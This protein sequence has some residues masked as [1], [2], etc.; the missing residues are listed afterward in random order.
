VAIGALNW[1]PVFAGPIFLVV[2]SSALALGLV[3]RVYASAKGI[4]PNDG[5][6][7]RFYRQRLSLEAMLL[8]AGLLMLAGLGMDSYLF[9][10]WVLGAADLNIGLQLAA[11]A[12][13]SI[14]VGAHLGLAGFLASMMDIE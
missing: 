11:L 13:T 14:I 8:S 1:Q 10:R 5:R 4:I 12:Q 7:A 2:G 3:S 9:L 6:W